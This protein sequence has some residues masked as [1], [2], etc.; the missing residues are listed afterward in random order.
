MKE[1]TLRYPGHI[2]YIQV[3]KKSGFFD[4]KEIEINGTKI[5]PIDFTNKILF[6]EWYLKDEEEEIT[7][8]K[9]TIKGIDKNGEKET[10]VYD[11]YDTYCKETQTSS[12]ARTT[13]Y[14]ATA[15]AHL[16]LNKL[17]NEVGVFPP[18]LVGKHEACYDFVLEYLKDRNVIYTKKQ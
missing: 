15:A 13:G 3:L 1:K 8:M 17:F 9:I 5:S 14:T 16:V 12:M 2:E 11:L 6:K 4:T 10:I 18:E 7:V